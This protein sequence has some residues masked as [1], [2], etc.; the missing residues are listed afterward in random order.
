M[1]RVVVVVGTR[2]NLVKLSALW[3]ALRQRPG[4]FDVRTIHTRQHDDPAM[5][6][7]LLE[8][9]ELPA[10]DVTLAPCRG[11]QAEQIGGMLPA[12][13]RV[14]TRERPEIVIVV[15]DVNS[16]AAGALAGR[17]A[18][19]PVVHVE[20]GLRSFDRSMPEETNRVLVDTVSDLLF[21][22]EPSAVDNLRR[23]GRAEDAV[24]L[25]GN[26]MIDALVR[27]RARTQLADEAAGASGGSPA[28]GRAER[29]RSHAVLT[30]HRPHNVDDPERLGGFVEALIAA[31]QLL[32][33]A[34]PLHPRTHDRLRHYGLD[35]RLDRAPGLRVLPPLRYSAM[36]RLLGEARVVLTDS[37]GLQEE[38]TFL[39]IPCL[40]LR[41]TTERPAT[42]TEG[43][44]RIVGAHPSRLVP[45]LERV[46]SGDAPQPRCPA[47][48]DGLAAERIA[49][50]LEGWSPPPERRSG[51]L[52]SLASVLA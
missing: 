15:G 1:R 29:G 26:V 25:V 17:M 24:H 45:E 18:G 42:V 20:A 50:V 40:T 46:L 16:T 13:V 28:D 11:S 52:G 22:S 48:W 30:L 32:P 10:P 6:H 27:V 2:P 39:G 5:F 34:L 14:I 37:G 9:L 12:L 3:H 21:A 51:R 33:V 4:R 47:L 44:N 43:T 41:D 8:D 38:S 23:E 49:D 35:R 19:I 31:S 7:A 36:L